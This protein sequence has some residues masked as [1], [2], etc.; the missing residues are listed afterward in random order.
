[1]DRMPIAFLDADSG[2]QVSGCR[3]A[4]NEFCRGRMHLFDFDA[5]ES[6]FEGGPTITKGQ[7]SSASV[8]LSKTGAGED[9][10]CPHKFD[11]AL[12]FHLSVGQDSTGFVQLEID[13]WSRLLLRIRYL[14]IEPDTF[15]QTT[16]QHLLRRRSSPCR[17]RQASL[18]HDKLDSSSPQLRHAH[19][20]S[21]LT[22]SLLHS[23]TSR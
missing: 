2:L 23:G 8:V 9:P 10:C 5:C 15:P 18:S 4:G 12:N 13:I 14:S 19:V 20:Q 21:Q 1:M 22:P 16:T 11:L 7:G 3:A 17:A 6:A